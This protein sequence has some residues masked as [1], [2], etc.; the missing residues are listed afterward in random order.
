[1]RNQGEVERGGAGQRKIRL[2]GEREKKCKQTEQKK[3]QSY[4]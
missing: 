3:R 2:R 4:C 1:M